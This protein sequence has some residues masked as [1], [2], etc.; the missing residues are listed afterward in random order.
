MRECAN[1]L[2]WRMCIMWRMG[3][4]RRKGESDRG[5]KRM[6]GKGGESY[7]R[8]IVP[9]I[10]RFLYKQNADSDYHIDQGFGYIYSQGDFRVLH[11]ATG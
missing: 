1:A 5:G 11:Q 9:G 10:Q 7:K 8:L 3:R 6:E 2:M 4:W